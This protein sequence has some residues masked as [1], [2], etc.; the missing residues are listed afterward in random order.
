MGAVLVKNADRM[1]LAA[2][3]LEEG[4]ELAFADG[5]AG[6]MPLSA[7]PEVVA[8]GGVAGLE[9]PNPY[10][11]VV[12]TGEGES[13]ELPWDFA[14][15]YCDP[16]YRPRI[17]AVA[18]HGRRVLGRRISG[19]R[20]GAGLRLEELADR[21]TIGRATLARIERGEQSPGFDTLSGIARAL[22]KTVPDLLASPEE[23]LDQ[24]GN[25]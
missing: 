15:H 18:R 12:T 9:L 21:A 2:A 7:L 20:N 19:L 22:S 4:I 17:E 14:R 6:L 10:E 5:C 16:L 1:M 25:Q 8:G 24:G 23:S 13:I 11:I 3:P